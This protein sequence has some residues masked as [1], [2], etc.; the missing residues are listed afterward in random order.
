MTKQVLEMTV[1]PYESPKEISNE[2]RA[3]EPTETPIISVAKYIGLALAPFSM[4]IY[5][6]CSRKSP[7]WKNADPVGKFLVCGIIAG[8]EAEKLAV[9]SVLLYESSQAFHIF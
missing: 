2:T 6:Y 7:D 8:A 4:P 5:L 3:A 9:Y 1:N